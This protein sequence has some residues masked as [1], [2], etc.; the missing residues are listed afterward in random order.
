VVEAALTEDQTPEAPSLSV[1][2]R[3]LAR[4]RGFAVEVAQG[5]R[6]IIADHRASGVTSVSKADGTPM[7]E[8]DSAVERYL[9]DRIG[10]AFPA[11]SIRG[12]ELPARTGG[13]GWVWHIDPID[14]TRAY[15]CDVP[16]YST[17]VGIEYDGA[18]MVGAADFPAL[19]ETISA[20]AGVGCF[21]G[22]D[23]VSV[24]RQVPTDGMYVMTSELKSWDPTA[25]GRML[26]ADVNLRTWGD[27]Y[28]YLLVATGRADA[29]ID[30]DAKEYDL[31]AVA[32]IISEAGGTFT[33][34]DGERSIGKGN[35]IGASTP[36]VADH[37]REVLLSK[38]E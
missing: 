11:D 37:L 4:L 27:A 33:S 23:R 2:G 25:L 16:L 32:V 12:E 20:A 24:R 3:N 9:R 30:C 29:M 15:V 36:E 6:A 31:A 8:T 22:V 34:L 26:N 28:G 5:A 21:H 35:A 1:D 17:L 19:G 10:T 14:G 18:V 13:N 38:L 7:T